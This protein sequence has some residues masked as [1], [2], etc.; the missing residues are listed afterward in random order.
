MLPKDRNESLLLFVTYD[1]AVP[2]A[3]LNK[4]LWNESTRS[5]SVKD[6]VQVI[7]SPLHTVTRHL[8]RSIL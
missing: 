6:L 1:N 7:Q 3:V 2:T 5:C 4:Y 8:Q